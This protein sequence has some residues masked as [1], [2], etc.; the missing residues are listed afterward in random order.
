MHFF[1]IVGERRESREVVRL[2]V[3]NA[4]QTELSQ[5]FTEQAEAFLAD[6]I[7]RLPFDPAYKPDE[8]ELHA[9]EGFSLHPAITEAVENPMVPDALVAADN[10]LPPIKAVFATVA[11]NQG[12]AASHKVYFQ[13][14]ERSQSLDRRFSI[15]V[16]QNTFSKLSS[17]GITLNQRLDAAFVDG[18]LLF[19][20][21]AMASRFLDLGHFLVEATEEEVRETLGHEKFITEDPDAALD[22]CDPWM[23]K[24]FSILKASEIL[25]QVTVQKIKSR[26]RKAGLAVATQAV[27]G[28]QAIVWPAEKKEAKDLLRFLNECY[29]H[30]ELSEKLYRT[31]SRQAV[32][33]GQNE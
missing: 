20:S 11:D 30:G 15:L 29:Y 17:P 31:N 33:L 21:F 13:R 14:F 28:R 25:D 23:R 10:A 12:E 8:N 26:A 9:I 6:D 19:R 24:Q 22:A 3:E 27:D 7:E 1:A 18:Q 5:L 16:T 4:L 32:N 2:A